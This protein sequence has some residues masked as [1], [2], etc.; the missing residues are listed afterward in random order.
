VKLERP[1]PI[2]H[3]RLSVVMPVYNE[4]RTLEEIVGRVLA[5]PLRVELLA[6]DDASTD[7]SREQLVQMGQDK[8]RT[9]GREPRS[10]GGSPRRL[11]TSS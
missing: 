11:A 9:G 10:D 4:R 1:R 6:V 2:P 3:P 7:G 5:V 8:G